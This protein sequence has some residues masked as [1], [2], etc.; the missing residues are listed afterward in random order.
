MKTLNVT[1]I[2]KEVTKEIESL[3]IDM[4]ECEVY[5]PRVEIKAIVRGD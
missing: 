5:K 4:S 3:R 1:Q 2:T